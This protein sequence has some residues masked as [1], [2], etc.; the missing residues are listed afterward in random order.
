[1]HEGGILSGRTI[2]KSVEEGDIRIS[3]FDPKHVNFRDRLN[4]A[5]YDLTLG[6]RLAVYANVVYPDFSGDIPGQMVYPKTGMNCYLDAAK[7]NEIV[8]YEMD[9]RGFML[10][11]GIGYLMHTVEKIHTDKFVPIIDGKSSIGRLF[12]FVHVTAGYGDPGFDGQYTLEVAVLHQLRVYPGMRF[13][14][15]RFH[16]I[17]GEV[18]SYQKK[19]NYKGALAEGPI[20]SQSYKMF[21]Q[22]QEPEA[23]KNDFVPLEKGVVRFNGG[24]QCDMAVGPCACGAWHKQED[25]DKASA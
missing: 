2:L 22:P 24:T 3:P 4:P 8:E 18:D 5:S 20:P 16:T 23:P 21:E 7:K 6:K 9:D 10:R 17:V 12:A 25:S 14:Q 13:C 11:P 1:M 19:G 15:M